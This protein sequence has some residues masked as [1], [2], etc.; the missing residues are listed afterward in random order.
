MRG[1][2]ER[3]WDLNVKAFPSAM[4]WAVSFWFVIESSSLL[5]RLVALLSANLAVI[6]SGLILAKREKPRSGVTLSRALHD[7]FVWKALLPIS[8]ILGL[9]LQN[10]RHQE[11]TTVVAKYFYSSIVL[12]S[13]I[14]WLFA[15]VVLL[16]ARAYLGFRG[17]EIAV[18]S[19][20]MNL[21]A[22]HK[23]TLAL[24]ISILLFTWP[25][26]FIYIFLALTLAQ[27]LTLPKMEEEMRVNFA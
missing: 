2:L 5:I 24:S 11:S 20:G 7:R 1:A 21:V 22:R 12:S 14:L 17:E 15:S 23:G 6:Y 9:A 26:F 13:L 27:S 4:L 16:P 18:L 10:A 3:I 19:L 8:V 25:L